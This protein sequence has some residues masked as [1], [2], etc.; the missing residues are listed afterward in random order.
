MHRSTV[1]PGVVTRRERGRTKPSRKK[2]ANPARAFGR[3][4]ERLLAV[5]AERG[6]TPH[7]GTAAEALISADLA[8]RRPDGMIEITEA[9]R[10][11]LIRLQLARSGA[12]DP[13]LGQHAAIAQGEI[14]TDIGRTRIILDACE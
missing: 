6:A 8:I 10:A 3:T 12:V 5:L 9:G 14:E 11:H 4:N 2:S 7:D 13:F 1:T